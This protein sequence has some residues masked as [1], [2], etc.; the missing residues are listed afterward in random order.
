MSWGRYPGPVWT[1]I[2]WSLL[3]GLNLLFAITFPANNKPPDPT[4]VGTCLYALLIV[5]TLLVL[6]P[7]TPNWLLLAFLSGAI[8]ATTMLV[9]GALTPLGGAVFALPYVVYSSYAALWWRRRVA[10]AFLLVMAIAYFAVLSLRGAMPYMLVTWLVIMTIC[11]GLVLLLGYLVNH[12]VSI[13]TVDPLTGLLNRTGL[14][15]LLVLAPTAGRRTQ[16]RT[17]AVID[18]DG[19]KQVNDTEGHRAGDVVLHDFGQALRG[20]A[21][22]DDIVAR[23]GGDEFLVVLPVTTE[24]QAEVFL[25]RLARS[26]DISWSSGVSAWNP[27]MSYDEAIA[28]ADERMYQA[29]RDRGGR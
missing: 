8:G 5:I 24:D 7:R 29:K 6:G 16:P 9:Y 21:R 11:M 22:A 15:T 26:T 13:A 4:T 23:T 1:L 2:A 20:I 12:L 28:R 19:L 14:M 10:V 27:D 3:S 25:A 17:V 18:L